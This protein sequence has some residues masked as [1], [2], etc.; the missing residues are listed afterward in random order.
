MGQGASTNPNKSRVN[1][2]VGQG[3]LREA[4]KANVIA[5]GD[6]GLAPSQGPAGGHGYPTQQ[7]LRGTGL[8]SEPVS[9]TILF[10][11]TAPKVALLK[12]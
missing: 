7:A 4:Q 6:V 10:I 9:V 8:H 12:L 3:R 5:Q 2:T 11:N 1:A